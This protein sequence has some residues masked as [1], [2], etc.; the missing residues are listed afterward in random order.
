[1]PGTGKFAAKCNGPL[2]PLIVTIGGIKYPIPAKQLIEDEIPSQPGDCFL[3]V[4]AREPGHGVDWVL[5]LP[6]VREYCQVMNVGTKEIGFAR[7]KH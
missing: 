4:E 3:S 1:M 5:G 7:H 2:K 6:F